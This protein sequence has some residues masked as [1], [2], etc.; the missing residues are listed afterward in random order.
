MNLSQ[1]ISKMMGKPS[2]QVN[3]FRADLTEVE[4]LCSI[5]TEE[6]LVK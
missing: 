2:K 1:L 6:L 5:S 3:K 4:M